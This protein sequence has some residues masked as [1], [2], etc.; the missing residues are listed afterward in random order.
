[1]SYIGDYYD[2]LLK[3]FPEPKPEDFKDPLQYIRALRSHF[4]MVN[5]IEAMKD[6]RIEAD[7]DQDKFEELMDKWDRDMEKERSRHRYYD[8]EV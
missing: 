4:D 7:G 1:M 3:D 2:E 8:D 6:A 5:M